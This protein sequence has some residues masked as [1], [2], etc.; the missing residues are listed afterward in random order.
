VALVIEHEVV[1]R[2][3]VVLD[4]CDD[5]GS[6]VTGCCNLDVILAALRGRIA[7]IEVRS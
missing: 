1:D 4:C 2:H 5:S 3:A 7:R 6:C